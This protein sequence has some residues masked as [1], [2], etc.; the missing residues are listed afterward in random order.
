[1]MQRAKMSQAA[2]DNVLALRCTLDYADLE[3]C[4]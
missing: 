1:M 2:P 3:S 4:G